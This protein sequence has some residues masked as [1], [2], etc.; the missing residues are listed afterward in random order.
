[1][2]G[3]VTVME[4]SDYAAWLSAHLGTPILSSP[5]K[6][7]FAE[8][9]CITCHAANGTGRAAFAQWPYGA[10]VLLA[11]GSTSPPMKPTSANRFCTER[12]NCGQISTFNAHL[13]RDS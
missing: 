10:Q 7:L 6:K 11:D 3:W 8:M 12:E 9:A 2:G 4:P 13:S 1:M 5:A